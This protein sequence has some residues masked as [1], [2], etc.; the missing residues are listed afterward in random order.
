MIIRIPELGSITQ[1]DKSMGREVRA[2]LLKDFP[3]LESVIDELIPKKLS[4]YTMRL[5]DNDKADLFI[6]DGEAICFRRFKRWYP[7]LKTVHKCWLNRP[8]VL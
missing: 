4:S 6:I 1:T 3:K 7:T 2:S 8:V 5:K